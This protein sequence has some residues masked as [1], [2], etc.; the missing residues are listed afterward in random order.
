[1]KG[2][3]L[4]GLTA[5]L[6][7]CWMCGTEACGQWTQPTADELSMTSIA[8]VPGAPAVYLYKEQTTD[9]GIHMISQYVRL[10]VLTEKG[11]EYANVEI[12]YLGGSSGFTVDSI[13]GRTIHPD[14]SVV[15][16]T[17][18]PYDK[19]VQKSAGFKVKEKVFTLPAVEVGSVIEYRYKLRYDDNILFSPDWTVQSDLYLR[20]AHFMW[21]P[22][23]GMVSSEDGKEVS[24]GV[25]WTP[26]LPDGAKVEQRAL[27]T[28]MTSASTAPT[29]ELTLDVHDIAPIPQEEYMPPVGSLSYRVLFYYS[30]VRTAKE[31]W[32]KHGRRWA[33]ERDK[34]IGP[35]KGV[36]A[37]VGSVVAAGDT[38]EVKAKKL[39]AAVMELENTDFTRER[40]TS[41]EKANGLKQMTSTDDVLARKRG[42]GDQLAQLFVAMCR[43]AGLKAYLMGVSDR[44]QRI[45]LSSYLSLQQ[46]DDDLAIVNIDGKEEF[47]DP[48]QR[49]CQPEHLAWKH[50]LIGGLR[51]TDGGS[52]LVTTPGE[53]YN[54][55]RVSRIADL[56]LDEHGMATGTAT[57]TYTGDPA[58]HWRQEA[59]KGDDASLNDDLKANLEHML[60]GGM[61]VRVTSVDNLAVYDKPLTVKYELKGAV[62]SAAGK[63]LAIPADVFVAN[64]KAHFPEPKRVLPVDMRYPSVSQDAVRIKYPASLTVESAPTPEKATMAEKAAVTNVATFETLV[65]PGTGSISMYRN[66]VNGRTIYLAD[67]YDNLRTFYSKIETADQGTLVL[68]RSA[69]GAAVAP[70]TGAAA[71]IK[72]AGN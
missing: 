46:L 9:D 59:L 61:E 33:K 48:G 69:A 8:E 58:L 12:P 66:L 35:N 5:A 54:A 21:R 4:S 11:K 42:S 19:L 15:M 52:A 22:S 2:T 36:Q 72:P 26:I 32:D 38:Q 27:H 17:D 14:G 25:A 44:S 63:R 57:L 70:G 13:S 29:S 7:V 41:E 31:F 30:D 53:T 56:A 43:A 24:Q 68:T 64:E 62:G 67:S 47:F 20:K 51:Q 50:T 3:R 10:K 23:A 37:Y 28:S 45:F 6:A 55:A 60:P 34:F 71:P 18:K 40:T 49:F 16:L 39:Y 65:K 1:M